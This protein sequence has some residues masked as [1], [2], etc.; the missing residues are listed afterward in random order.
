MGS[1]GDGGAEDGSEPVD[2][3]LEWIE[4]WIELKLAVKPAVFKKMMGASDSSAPVL[5]FLS[6]PDC[7]RLFVYGKDKD[8]KE[9]LCGELPPLT[10]RRRAVYF[11]KV[12]RRA[13]SAEDIEQLVMPGDLLPNALSQLHRLCETAYLPLL[14]N[15]ENQGSCTAPVMADLVEGL[16]S[17]RSST[18][19]PPPTEHH[20]DHT[21][22]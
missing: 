14:A 16:V 15:P 22:E 17:L 2:S 8:Y 7:R 18:P 4:R 1:G 11:V 9:L 21:V 20:G 3:R 13:V 12:E 6:N 10:L 5:H 19:H